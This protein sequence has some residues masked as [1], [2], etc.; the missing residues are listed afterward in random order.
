MVEYNFFEFNTAIQ[1]SSNEKNRY[2][3]K[4]IVQQID[5]EKYYLS[6]SFFKQLLT[7]NMQIF[8]YLRGDDPFLQLFFDV[9]VVPEVP[10][11]SALGCND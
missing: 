2:A 4:Y 8:Y 9:T 1:N 5:E 7:E 3:D 6:H 10:H 11:L